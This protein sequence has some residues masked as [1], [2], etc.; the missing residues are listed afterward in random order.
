MKKEKFTSAEKLLE[1]LNANFNRTHTAYEKAFWI[2]HIGDHSV[3]KHMNKAQAE[4]D[5]FRANANLKNEVLFF[6]KN[7]KTSKSDR[8]KL[9]A[10][11]SFF[12]MYQMSEEAL[13]VKKEA[14]K[15]E[16]VILTKH[17]TRKEGYI[18]PKT[19]KFIPASENKMRVIMRTNPDEATRR[20]CF[21]AT[22]KLALDTL[23]EYIEIIK[24]R[25]KFAKILGYDNF[26]AYK[27]HIDEK[28]TMKELFAIFDV[29]YEK[30]KFGFEKIRELEKTMPGL[31]KP[32]N[33]GYMMT[34]DFTKE[35]D[36]YF[37]FDH[38]LSYWGKSFASLGI[39]FQGGSLN[40]DLLDRKG[41]YSNGF[42]HWPVV[43][44]YKKD[45]GT[46]K[47]KRIPATAGFTCN[48]IPRQIGSGIQGINTL[49]H[50]GGHAA[51]L[52][53]SV[54]TESCLNHEYPPLSVS[55]AETQSMFIEAISNSIE[56]RTRYAKNSAGEPYPL[57]I[58]ERK[59][60]KL[61]PM[62]PLG[63]MGMLF[64]ST[65]EKEIYECKKLSHKFVIEAA[66]KVSKKY[67]DF[68]N[69]SLR[70]LNVPHIY[71]WESSAYYHGY[72]L[73]QLGVEQWRDYF[74]KKYGHIVD[75]PKIGKEMV[76]VW[77]YGSLYPSKEF[78]KM[79][80]GSPL[81]PDAFIENVTQ[82]ME[83]LI[84]KAKEKIEHLKKVPELKKAIKLNAKIIMVHGK[85]KIA[86]NSKSFEDMDMKYRKW[87]KTL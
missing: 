17:T 1:Y 23:D 51:H 9:H 63:L 86:D 29:I 72:A 79:A 4:R 42:C 66:K 15:L 75:N 43:V 8:E 11:K 20:A 60:A 48:A 24:L 35:E 53:N 34:G 47:L 45:K 71:S 27:L 68:S 50:E 40:L 44:Q 80:T 73:A 16:A 69:D 46:G 10:W 52:L 33:F 59:V 57:E 41:K 19:K 76:K 83:S 28:M 6:I 7:G 62:I 85:K 87:L 70:V 64:V 84:A 30:T 18:D 67:M 21:E 56:W 14:A 78:I 31:R 26:Y 32:W 81:S 2:S 39:D 61:H 13:A 82:S 74:Y 65:F 38:A 3:D 58:Y 22:E 49:F 12:S 54:Q 55:W 25:N 77:K 36:S 5:N 37:Q